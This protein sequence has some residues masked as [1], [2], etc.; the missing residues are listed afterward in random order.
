M[1]E[2]NL[3]NLT[4]TCSFAN[5]T[6]QC[7]LICC[8]KTTIFVKPGHVL[9]RNYR[10]VFLV[11]PLFWRTILGGGQYRLTEYL[12]ISEDC[13]YLVNPSF[14]IVTSL[15][16]LIFWPLGDGETCCNQHGHIHFFEVVTQKM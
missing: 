15:H 8:T 10:L 13:G 6:K 16:K 7:T 14:R 9:R 4:A 3:S 5:E 1:C 11:F 12:M 2:R